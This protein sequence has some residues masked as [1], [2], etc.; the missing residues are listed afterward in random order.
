VEKEEELTLGG[1]AWP[2]C[3]SPWNDREE[4]ER[5]RR[6]GLDLFCSVRSV[7]AGLARQAAT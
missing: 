3:S 6:E 7:P 2:G 4:K 1:Q 5:E